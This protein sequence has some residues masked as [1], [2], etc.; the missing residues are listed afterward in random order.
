LLASVG[1]GAM[2]W[3]AGTAL[4]P[5]AGGTPVVAAVLGVMA[6]G[7]GVCYLLLLE[8][9]GVRDGREVLAVVRERIGYRE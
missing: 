5:V 9:L 8:L 2:L 4:L 1:V 6:A 3:G 7:A